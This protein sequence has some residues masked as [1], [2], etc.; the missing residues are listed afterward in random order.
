MRIRDGDSSDPGWKKVGSGIW[1]KH[2]GSATLLLPTKVETR[3]TGNSF[4]NYFF[5]ELIVIIILFMGIDVAQPPLNSVNQQFLGCSSS[6]LLRYS[7]I[8]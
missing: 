2:P 4:S 6:R 5:T 3:I 7:F 1:D 8:F